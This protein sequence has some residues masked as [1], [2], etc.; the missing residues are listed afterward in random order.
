MSIFR[1][2]PRA[3]KDTAVEG[4][5]FYAPTEPSGGTRPFDP[6]PP[7]AHRYDTTLDH[8]KHGEPRTEGHACVRTALHGYGW[9][10]VGDNLTVSGLREFAAWLFEVAIDIE[11]KE[12]EEEE[13]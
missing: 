4:R 1:R 10:A 13:Q 8:V 3:T 11:G 12:V 9:R 2:K 7:P 6:N 5:G